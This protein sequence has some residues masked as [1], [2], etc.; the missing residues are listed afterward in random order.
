M[1]QKNHLEVQTLSMGEG[2]AILGLWLSEAGR[3]LQEKQRNYILN[4]FQHSG[5]P[6]YLK[7]T[8]EEAR[9][10]KSFDPL[11]ELS[12]DIPGILCDLFSRLSKESN[13]GSLLVSRSLGYL[14]EAKNGLSEDEVVDILSL[15]ETVMTDFQNRSPKSPKSDHLPVV[16]W[17][18]LYFDLQVYL[19]E[20]SADG[21]SLLAF[22][23]PTTFKKALDKYLSGE[24]KLL[25]F[26]SLAKYFDTK[27]MYIQLKDRSAP[28]LRKLSEQPHALAHAQQWEQLL[29]I[30]AAPHW[31]QAYVKASRIYDLPQVIEEARQVCLQ[32]DWITALTS[33]F[34]AVHQD[35]WR[36]VK[37]PELGLIA[38]Q[39]DYHLSENS[40]PIGQAILN[41][42]EM[43]CQAEGIPFLKLISRRQ[44]SQRTILSEHDYPISCVVISSDGNYGA[45][46]DQQGYMIGFNPKTAERLWSQRILTYLYDH[47]VINAEGK[48]PKYGRWAHPT[49]MVVANGNPP[50]VRIGAKEMFDTSP[51]SEYVNH[52]ICLDLC[53]GNEIQRDLF[54]WVIKSWDKDYPNHEPFEMTVSPDGERL[55]L[56]G[57]CSSISGVCSSNEPGLTVIDS[58]SGINMK[59]EAERLSELKENRLVY[60][61]L[62]MAFLK[63]DQSIW[64]ENLVDQTSICCGK[65]PV[66]PI[67]ASFAKDRQQLILQVSPTR[68]ILVDGQV[69]TPPQVC[70]EVPEQIE[71]WLVSNHWLVCLTREK[72]IHILDLSNRDRCL[73]LQVGN[74]KRIISTSQPGVIRLEPG[75]LYLDL[76]QARI[77]SIDPKFDASLAGF[78]RIPGAGL[79]GLNCQNNRLALWTLADL[80]NSGNTSARVFRP[81]RSVTC[82]LSPDL[83]EKLEKTTFAFS[84][85]ITQVACFQ[86]DHCAIVYDRSSGRIM[87]KKQC[88]KEI[89]HCRLEPND[90]LLLWGGGWVQ[91][92]DLDTGNIKYELFVKGEM[93]VPPIYSH[94]LLFLHTKYSEEI[95]VIYLP[96]MATI[97]RLQLK[98]DLWNWSYNPYSHELFSEGK[99]NWIWNTRLPL[100]LLGGLSSFL[101]HI[102]AKILEHDISPSSGNFTKKGLGSILPKYNAGGREIN[103]GS[104]SLGT[105]TKPGRDNGAIEAIYLSQNEKASVLVEG[106]G[107]LVRS[108]IDSHNQVQVY[109]SQPLKNVWTDNKGELILSQDNKGG[110]YAF[111]WIGDS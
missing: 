76:E 25:C 102:T 3:K 23:H 51:S 62:R 40:S 92:V 87:Y 89:A 56:S 33:L 11:P 109:C 28:D 90:H 111:E 5:L 63:E 1:P 18:R 24:E 9:L 31:I 7:L 99:E 60:D 39:L 69:I 65:L 38:C 12:D 37:E 4:K 26:Q 36:F 57:V 55:L 61:G 91:I 110:L 83:P 88:R 73:N 15:D 67:A 53:N 97:R 47:W 21:S 68:L 27:P 54:G 74:A 8:F 43:R 44:E 80:Q 96:K 29:D 17:S 16:V 103:F 85:D 66:R 84:P 101:L 108:E 95:R 58:R 45:T 10:W 98:G 30:L 64:I 105:P 70:L 81:S 46:I 94:P 107:R 72:Q 78:V 6:L 86:E 32:Q 20:R 41:R 59:R 104:A 2:K 42:L 75:S 14:A 22:Y 35:A 79:M 48:H 13:H 34:E 106:T 71:H 93:Q 100:L 50:Q 82:Q 77:I 49:Q 19:T 52:V